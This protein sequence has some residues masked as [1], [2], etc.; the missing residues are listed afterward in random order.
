MKVM[1]DRFLAAAKATDEGDEREDTKLIAI[2]AHNNMKPTMMTFVAKHRDFFKTVQ[3]TTTGSTGSALQKKLGLRIAQKVAS[4]PLGGDQEIGSFITND[5]VGG[6]FFFIDPLSAHPHE[7]DIKALVRLCEVHN[8]P[9]A[10]NP[11]TGEALVHYFSTGT[12]EALLYRNTRRSS[13]AAVKEYKRQQ[14]MIIKQVADSESK[15]GESKEGE[16]KEGESKVGE[17]KEGESKEA[18]APA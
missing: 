1:Q 8:C 5:M 18:A 2:V 17:S 15:E 9:C 16:S 3:I 6:V 13:S 7:A 14:T 12:G 4:G 10:T 11:A